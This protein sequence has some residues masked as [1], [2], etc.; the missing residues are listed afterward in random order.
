MI[1][2]YVNELYLRNADTVKPWVRAMPSSHVFEAE[3]PN[4]LPAGTHVLS[5]RARDEFGR[6]HHAH[7]ILEVT[8]SSAP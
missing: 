5:V 4:D 6:T 8:G 1:D 7:R 3:L 2:P